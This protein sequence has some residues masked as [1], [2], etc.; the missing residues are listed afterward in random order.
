MDS[1]RDLTGEKQVNRDESGRFIE[2]TSGNPNG[3]PK[4][5][6]SITTTIKKYYETH[7]EEFEVLCKEL[8]ED[9]SMRKL[10]WNYIDGKPK[11]LIETTDSQIVFVPSEIGEKYNLF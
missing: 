7:P 9:R 1:Q 4:G 10:L 6:L 3:R 2:G 8:R 11:E 5:S